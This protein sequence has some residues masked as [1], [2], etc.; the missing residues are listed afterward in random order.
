MVK[1]PTTRLAA[2]NNLFEAGE[3]VSG[4]IVRAR[5]PLQPLAL[6]AEEDRALIEAQQAIFAAQRVMEGRL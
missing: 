3:A 2:R 4:I 6:T 1:N 5:A